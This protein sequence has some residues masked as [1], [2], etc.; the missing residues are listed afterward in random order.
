MSNSD[1][2]A[3]SDVAQKGSAW[4]DPKVI[5]AIISATA[6]I[7]VALCVLFNDIPKMLMERWWD[8]TPTVVV[9]TITASPSPATAVTPHQRPPDTL[10]PTLTPSSTP[11]ETPTLTFTPS[12]TPT[13]TPT[14]TPTPFAT[15][16]DTPTATSTPSPMPTDTPTATA[17]PM[18]TYTPTPTPTRVLLELLEPPQDAEIRV[19]QIYFTWEWKGALLAANEHFALRMWRQE[20]HFRERRSITWTD[21]PEYI[22]TLDYPPV[23]I[24]FS[25]GHYYWNIGVVHEICP[26]HEAQ[27]CWKALYESEPR[28]LNICVGRQDPTPTQPPDTPTPPPTPTPWEP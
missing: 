7:I 8:S 18:P 10:T 15:P 17:T 13:H 24:E 16:T 2:Q 11:T 22:L 1:R 3:T 6:T 21:K 25:P 27:E 19:S 20:E 23:N 9:R 5:V 14:A 4:R 12:P 26:H 28:R